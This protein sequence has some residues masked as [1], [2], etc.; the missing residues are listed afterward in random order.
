MTWM[1]ELQDLAVFLFEVH[2]TAKRLRM[3]WEAGH[4]AAAL[5]YGLQTGNLSTETWG[6]HYYCTCAEHQRILRPDN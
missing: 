2:Q 1:Q 6:Y 3:S 5:R 4:E